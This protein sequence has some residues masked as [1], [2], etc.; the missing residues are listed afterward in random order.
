MTTT[1]KNPVVVAPVPEVEE[2]RITLDDIKHRA[3]HVKEIAVTE[4]KDAVGR[5]MGLDT[6]KQLLIAAGVVIAVVSLA[7]FLG[8]RKGRSSLYELMD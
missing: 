7:Y 6:S 3:Q 2:D 8:A 5:V 1:P 4:T